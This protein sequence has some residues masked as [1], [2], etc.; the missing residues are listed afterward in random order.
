MASF[1]IAFSPLAGRVFAAT[2]AKRS[3]GSE[4]EKGHLD[5]ILRGLQK[6]NQLLETDSILK[7]V[8][9]KNSGTTSLGRRD[10]S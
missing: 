9:E 2:A 5:W 7:M 6:E 1:T 10:L 4:E 8:E 3:G